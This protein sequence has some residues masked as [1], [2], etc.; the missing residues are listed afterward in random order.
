MPADLAAEGRGLLND[1]ESALPVPRAPGGAAA[2][3]RARCSLRATA[4]ALCVVAAVLALWRSLPRGRHH[5]YHS[6]AA[7]SGELLRADEAGSSCASTGEESCLSSRCCAEEGTTCYKK[8]DGWAA[9][10]LSCDPGKG[11]WPRREEKGFDGEAWSC[12]VWSDSDSLSLPPKTTW[13][14]DTDTDRS[15]TFVLIQPKDELTAEGQLCQNGDCSQCTGEGDCSKTRCCGVPGFQCF[16]KDLGWSSCNATCDPN[17]RSD[18]SYDD[19]LGWTCV[20]LGM[21][22]PGHV[23]SWTPCRPEEGTFPTLADDP[24][25]AWASGEGRAK[26]LLETLSLKNKIA[27]LRGQNGVWP[28]DRHGFVGYIN[29]QSALGNDCAMPLA[30]NDGPQG[31]N[32]YQEKL[33]GTSTQFPCLLAVAATFDPETSGK[34]AGAIADEFVTKG[35][36][37]LLGPDIEVTRAPLA[38]RSFE[39]LT[40]EEP[41]LGATLVVPFVRAVQERG[42]IATIKHWLDNNEEIF[43]RTMNVDVGDRAQHEI[44]MP[45]FKAAIDAGASAVMCA[46]NKVYGTHACENKHLLKDLLRKNL[47]FRGFIMSDWE[48]THDAKGSVEAGLDM[49]MPGGKEGKFSQLEALI[50]SGQLTEDDIDEMA[51]HVLTSMYAI[52]HFDGKFHFTSEDASLDKDATSDEARDVA[53]DTIVESAV[54]LK[55]EGG[56][57]PLVV[58]PLSKVALV[59]KY[60]DVAFDQRPSDFTVYSGGQGSTY[61]GGGSGYVITNDER[62]ITIFEGIRDKLPSSEVTKSEDARGAKGADV[63]II[64]VAAHSE[65]GWDRE[66]I[67]MPDAT[68][69]VGAVRSQD[70]EQ[71]IVVIAIAPGAVTTPW[72]EKADAVLMLFMPGEQVGVAVAQLLIG[73]ASPGGRL[74]VSMPAVNEERFTS[75]QYPGEPPNKV[76]MTAH[77]WEGVL[78]GYRWNVANGV[79]SAFP[80]GFGLTYGELE[81]GQP[82]ISTSGTEATITVDI[83]NKGKSDAVAVPQVYVG[84]PSLL[85][86]VRQLRGFQKVRLPAGRKDTATIKLGSKDWSFYD[87][88]KAEWACATDVGEKVIISVGYDSSSMVFGFEVELEGKSLKAKELATPEAREEFL[89]K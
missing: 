65:E 89:F 8:D 62:T 67:E 85:P 51:G 21:R 22:T 44:Y 34:Y 26:K 11:P 19:N 5:S 25:A 83:I 57:L 48:A 28:Y 1:A 54:L 77:F 16:Q 66:S 61:S 82:K 41:F 38:G 80:F 68:D 31:Y 78:V 64:C 58:G 17:Y 88:A 63:A 14:P 39:T 70:P 42:I 7:A 59:G 33:A 76:N 69:L 86:A 13:A 81:Y 10:W 30:L 56:A 18:D 84:F 75:Q 72:V 32:H 20:K 55:N 45:V 40:G 37:V 50:S 23:R 46:Y 60:C 53:R 24:Q 47:G 43:R 2:A 36:N 27:L 35:A 79:P 4:A 6:T 29:P 49:E 12:E 71:T 52:G 9:C 73:E 15:D 3:Q 74:P 87:R